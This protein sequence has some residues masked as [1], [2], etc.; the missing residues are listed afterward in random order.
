MKLA[1]RLLWKAYVVFAVEVYIYAT[2]CF[3]PRG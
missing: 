1:L 3:W 2:Y